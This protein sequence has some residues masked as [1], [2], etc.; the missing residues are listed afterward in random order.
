MNFYAR[1]LIFCLL[2][3]PCASLL[4]C[5]P[6]ERAAR[7]AALPRVVYGFDREFPP[8]SYE[9]P[10]GKPIGF[11]VELI[12]SIFRD[13]AA[14]AM[15][16]LNWFMVQPELSSGSITMTSGMIRTPQRARAF[17]FSQRPTFEVKIR[18]FTKVY[19][20]VPNASFLRG[21]SVAVEDGSFQLNLLREFGGVNIKTFPSRSLALRA[22]FNE[23]VDA[24]C[25]P[26]ES[27]YFYIRKLNYGAITNLGS[28]LATAELRIAVHRDRGDVL[29]MVD[30]GLRELT[31]SGEYDR[32]YRRWF[33]TE[34]NAQDKE[35]LRKGAQAAAIN[36]YAPYGKL[37]MGAALLTATGKLIQG[38]NVEN[39]EPRLALS[40]L[41]AALARAVQ[42]NELEIRAAALVDQN[43]ALVMPDNDD[44]QALYEFG[45]GVL[46]LTPA[47]ESPMVAQLLPNPVTRN[48][49]H[50]ELQ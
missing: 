23:E 20:R 39:A 25:G 5:A 38:C 45:R 8:F 26:D 14:L 18:F 32:I 2:M 50:V 16:P 19:R 41:R 36:A 9:D 7:A 37:N 44:F 11:D 29:R 3:L 6:G 10:G 13:K 15:R 31:Q 21:Q 27:S 35:A 40:A 24:Y 12:E 42:E 30:D 49:F 46:V 22:L 47:G 48:I 17:V 28:P 1:V 43:G 4:P 33:I 34:L